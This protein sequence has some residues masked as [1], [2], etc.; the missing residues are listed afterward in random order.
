M[1]YNRKKMIMIYVH[2]FLRLTP[3]YMVVLVVYINV[4]LH[5]AVT[6]DDLSCCR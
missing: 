5:V 1:E 6:R 2:R 3:V 4:C